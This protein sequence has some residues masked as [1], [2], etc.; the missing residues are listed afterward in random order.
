MIQKVRKRITL[1][2]T[3][4]KKYRQLR[5]KFKNGGRN[6]RIKYLTL[7]YNDGKVYE[8]LAAGSVPT[9]V[10]PI[11]NKEDGEYDEGKYRVWVASG[12]G[13]LYYDESAPVYYQANTSTGIHDVIEGTGFG[14]SVN[15]GNIQVDGI[16]AGY[17]VTC[18]SAAGVQLYTAEAR[19]RQSE[20]PGSCR[21]RHGYH[22]R[23]RRGQD[24]SQQDY[25]QVIN[26]SIK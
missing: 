24:P 12:K 10:I 26:N 2:I 25:H 6:A 3:E 15:G 14:I 8:D 20:L 16:K 17:T 4:N 11:N 13:N 22:Q 23:K 21:H 1:P 9:N 5:F 19:S 18:T 7:T